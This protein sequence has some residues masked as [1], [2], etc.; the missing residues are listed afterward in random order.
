VKE[1]VHKFNFEILLKDKFPFKPPVVTTRTPFSNPSLADGRDLLAHILPH[2]G[3]DMW[4]PSTNLSELIK[5][6]PS[7]IHEVVTSVRAENSMVGQF[8]LG[9]QYEI[10]TWINNKQCGVYPCE[11][12]RENI[13]YEE[14]SATGAK[15]LKKVRTIRINIYLVVTETILLVLETD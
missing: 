1:P 3:T 15:T 11:L 9:Q 7:F 6:I 4:R 12:E 2:I 13:Y 5:Q 10:S 14:D 8:H